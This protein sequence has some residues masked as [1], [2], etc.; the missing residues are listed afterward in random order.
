MR[1]NNFAETFK[2]WSVRDET[3]VIVGAVIVVAYTLLGGFWA[4]S[5]T[6]TLQGFVMA[7]TSIA[8]PIAC[9]FT[10]GFDGLVD[11]VR[12]GTQPGFASVFGAMDTSFA[13]GFVLGTLGIGLGY[14]GQPHVVNRF[15]R[16][17][18]G[19][20]DAHRAGP[21]RSRGPSSCTRG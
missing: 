3:S 17:G 15:M 14:P 11:G 13:L 4:V 19:A 1:A 12:S 16:C 10:L 8:L 6:D 18:W 5:L 2:E 9:L 21:W 7:L 20:R